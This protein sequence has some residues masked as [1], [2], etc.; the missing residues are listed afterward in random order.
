MPNLYAVYKI[1]LNDTSTFVGVCLTYELATMLRDKIYSQWS[2]PNTNITYTVFR[3]ILREWYRHLEDNEELTLEEWIKDKYPECTQEMLD[4]YFTKGH[5]RI[6]Q[7]QS[8][9]NKQEIEQWN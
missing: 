4:Y 9:T 6:S 3:N 5:V 7:I 8:F 2:Y 1:G